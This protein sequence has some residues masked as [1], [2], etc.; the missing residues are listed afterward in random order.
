M[1]SKKQL[2][3]RVLEELT[4]SV[5]LSL[6]AVTDLTPLAESVKPLNY[7]QSSGHAG[8]MKYMLRSPE[9]LCHPQSLVPGAKSA[10]CI[11]VR[12]TAEVP[13]PLPPGFGRVARYAWGADYHEVL[14]QRLAAFVGA[15]EHA[16]GTAVIS[17]VF[18][19]SVPILERSLAA[20]AGLGF[21]GKNTMLIR[22]GVGSYFFISEVLWDVEVEV[23]RPALSVLDGSCGSCTRCMNACPTSAFD[24]AYVLDAR[25]CISYLTIEYRGAFTEEQRRSLDQWVFGC[26]VCQEV[27]PFNHG[28][29]KLGC[30]PELQEFSKHQGVGPFLNLEEVLNLRTTE[31]YKA[32]F[33]GTALLR[34][35]REGLVRNALSVAANSGAEFLLPS[36]TDC[37]EDK[38]ALVRRTALATLSD[39][40]KSGA[41]LPAGRSWEMLFE[42]AASDPDETVRAEASAILG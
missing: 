9:L 8:S 27:C 21:I 41:C 33:K 16:L 1:H 32:R 35:K 20:R 42:R 24:S 17:R 37:L 36:I 13:G 4:R 34:A 31:H 39:F 29:M 14:R 18:S 5:G 3:W 26:D 7:W 38:E 10:I 2:T 12:Y 23:E 22:P 30:P 25:K 6:V 40:R 15:V 11:A 19:D 28:S